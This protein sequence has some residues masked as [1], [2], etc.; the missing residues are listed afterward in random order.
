[1]KKQS[2][3]K[4]VI[5]MV[6]FGT[7][8]I[9]VRYID[10]E[11][12]FIAFTRGII[13]ALILVL[14][15]LV[16]KRRPSLTAIKNN[17]VWLL[18]SGACIGI[19]WILLFE[20]YS[21]T[22]IATST[23]CYYMSPVFVIIASPLVLGARVPL[24]K[25]ICVGVALV[26]MVLVSGIVGGKGVGENG[27]IGV[28]LALGAALFYATVTLLN[29]KLK[30][31]SSYDTTIVQLAAAA[32]TVLPYTIFAESN[33][34]SA[35]EPLAVI[36]ILVVGIVHTG[37]AYMLFFSSIQELP[38][39]TVALFSYLDPIVAV[40]LSL[41]INEPM[42]LPMGIGAVLIIVALIASEIDLKA[43]FGVKK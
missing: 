19:N 5:S 39:E 40:L 28:A 37:V 25:W 38:T 13:G 11:R 8:G 16:M 20:S 10:A 22:T 9:F 35:L 42:T 3:L 31:I 21:Y 41:F 6:I 34:F 2:L 18:I 15:L 12:G 7:I 36:M 14:A 23:L 32:L 27:I 43:L 17:L 29:K 24:K 4:L 26:G 33:D 30:D 1:M